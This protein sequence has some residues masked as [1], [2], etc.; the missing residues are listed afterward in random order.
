MKQIET[1]LALL[2]GGVGLTDDII[3]ETTLALLM[4]EEWDRP[5]VEP[6]Q[7]LWN[8]SEEEWD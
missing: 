7:S 3:R 8:S 5:M 2:R 6:Y 1:T 4:M